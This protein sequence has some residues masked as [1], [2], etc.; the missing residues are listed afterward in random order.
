MENLRNGNN[1]LQI[2]EVT[3][4]VTDIT[5]GL[6]F[7]DRKIN[8]SLLKEEKFTFK[9]GRIIEN[10]SNRFNTERK[11]I[12]KYNEYGNIVEEI[13]FDKYDCKIESIW[14][15]YDSN[16]MIVSSDTITNNNSSKWKYAN[17][18]IKEDNSNVIKTD[19]FYKDVYNGYYK[20]FFDRNNTKWKYEDYD[21]NGYLKFKITYY[22]NEY[23]VLY[24]QT[25]YYPG[26]ELKEIFLVHDKNCTAI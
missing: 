13:I 9:N 11:S 16:N 7:K 8:K 18:Q 5:S 23:K 14:K 15:K 10:V 1:I 4:K 6:F 17:T 21:K 24:K 19:V 22:Y 3:F 20:T 25:E 12:S 26:S 2:K